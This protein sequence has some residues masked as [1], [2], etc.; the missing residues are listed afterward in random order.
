MYQK[1][2]EYHAKW[3]PERQNRAES[4]Y[5]RLTSRTMWPILQNIARTAPERLL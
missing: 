4:C 2:T 1:R 5:D 3:R